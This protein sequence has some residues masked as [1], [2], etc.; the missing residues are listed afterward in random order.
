MRLRSLLFFH[1]LL[2]ILLCVP[3]ASAVAQEPSAP[4]EAAN[5]VKLEAK[6]GGYKLIDV[7]TLA[8]LYKKGGSDLLLIDTRQEWEYQAG[9]IKG[10]LV[11]PMEPTWLARLTQRGAMEQMLGSDKDKSLVFY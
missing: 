3:C 2:G 9:H 4:A 7:D 10:A 5:A 6:K 1:I 11:F 8:A